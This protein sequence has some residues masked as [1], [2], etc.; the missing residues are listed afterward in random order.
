MQ[1]VAFTDQSGDPVPDHTVPHF[2][3]HRDPE[4]VSFGLILSHNHDQN[5]AGLGSSKLINLLII[6]CF[7]KGIRFFHKEKATE[8]V[9]MLIISFYP[10]IFWQPEPFFHLWCSFFYENHVPLLSAGF[11]AEMS[12]SLFFTSI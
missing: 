12:S 9:A 10:L 5:A 2:L 1:P 4:P 6:F 3:T 7:R 8:T 11:S